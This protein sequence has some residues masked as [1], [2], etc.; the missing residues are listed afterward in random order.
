M[1]QI[2]GYTGYFVDQN[3]NLYSNRH[4][5][6]NGIPTKLIQFNL[7]GYLAIKLW[8]ENN[9]VKTVLS[10][11]IIAKAFIPNPEKKPHI[12]HID[13]N[14]R[15]NNISNLRWCTHQENMQNKDYVR[16]ILQMDKFGNVINEFKSVRDAARKL[17]INGG[18]LN[19]C[20]NGNRK[21]AGGFLFKYA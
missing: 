18:N 6:Y 7:K 2:E 8:D 9:K 17:L 1:K 21:S 3:G 20:V 11:K 19:E 15:N 14:K 4:K 16:H 13:R 10:H 12:D 5:K